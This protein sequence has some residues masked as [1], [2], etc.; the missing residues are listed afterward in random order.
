MDG[1]QALLLSS[2]NK[3]TNL[4]TQNGT[5][6]VEGQQ[7]MPLFTLNSNFLGYSTLWCSFGIC[8]HYWV[9]V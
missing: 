1:V 8:L 2:S 7:R 9:L 5:I 4:T 6:E 3:G